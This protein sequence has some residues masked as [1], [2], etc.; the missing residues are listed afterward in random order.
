MTTHPQK[1]LLV[2]AATVQ[3][4]MVSEILGLIPWIYSDIIQNISDD[5]F[6]KAK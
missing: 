3:D 5:S 2:P 4:K 1:F 6:T